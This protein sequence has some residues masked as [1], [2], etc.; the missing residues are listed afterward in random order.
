MKLKQKLTCIRIF[1]WVRSFDPFHGYQTHIFQY[2]RHSRCHRNS[3]LRSSFH[4]HWAYRSPLAPWSVGPMTRGSLPILIVHHRNHQWP[5]KVHPIQKKSGK[6]KKKKKLSWNAIWPKQ[7]G[8]NGVSRNDRHNPDDP[9]K[10]NQNPL[11]E[12]KYRSKLSKKEFEFDGW[13][14]MR[15]T[16]VGPWPYVL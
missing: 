9:E 8:L 7:A 11:Q 12:S 2:H 15:R 3:N 16:L 6:K 4:L 10:F 1:W 5:I 13:P 14:I